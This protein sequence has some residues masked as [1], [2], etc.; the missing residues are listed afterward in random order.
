MSPGSD[1]L[2]PGGGKYACIK[3]TW[4]PYV[5]GNNPGS[6]FYVQYKKSMETQYLATQEQLNQDS[7]IG[8][9]IYMYTAQKARN[10]YKKSKPKNL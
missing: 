1:K 10:F 2:C 7:I 6:H 4:Q 5:D 9:Y 3:V 8:M